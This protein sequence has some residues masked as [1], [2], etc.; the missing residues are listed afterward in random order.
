M[1]FETSEYFPQYS[2]PAE[3]ASGAPGAHSEN[4][5]EPSGVTH[6]PLCADRKPERR[7]RGAKLLRPRHRLQDAKGVPARPRRGAKDR[8]DIL[9]AHTGDHDR[10]DT[11][12]R[13]VGQP[14]AEDAG[15]VLHAGGIGIF[16]RAGE[17][18]GPDIRGHGTLDLSVQQ[19][20]DG[21]QRV[22][23]PDIGKARTVRNERGDGRKARR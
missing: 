8:R 18:T 4:G 14:V 9:P 21:K 16:L 5:I 1:S 12:R 17:R 10:I 19:K 3:R 13:N 11:V 15:K 2:S 22:V 20:T 23:C 7:Q 6:K